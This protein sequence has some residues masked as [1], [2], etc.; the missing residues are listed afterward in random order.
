[1]HF[2]NSTCFYRIFG[3]YELL[4][5]CLASVFLYCTIFTFL[6]GDYSFVIELNYSD[7]AVYLI[8]NLR[9]IIIYLSFTTI[10]LLN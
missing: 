7:F 5:T 1:M 10:E 6:S 9:P 8:T 2:L 3:D 4:S